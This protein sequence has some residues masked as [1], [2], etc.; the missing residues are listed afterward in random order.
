MQH[1]SKSNIFLFF[2][3]IQF[4]CFIASAKV[5][6][7]KRGGFELPRSRLFGLAY[8]ET[9]RGLKRVYETVFGICFWEPFNF[10]SPKIF[11][12]TGQGGDLKDTSGHEGERNQ[13]KGR[14][15]SMKQKLSPMGCKT[16]FTTPPYESV[17]WAPLP[18]LLPNSLEA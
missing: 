12:R 10:N 15:M 1:R 4:Q 11:R 18:Y 5:L 16:F 6:I 17:F 7:H 9:T 2:A 8:I 13:M 3:H 14:A